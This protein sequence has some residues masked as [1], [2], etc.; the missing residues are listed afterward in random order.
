[1]LI[2]ENL[3]NLFFRFRKVLD[4]K[5][6]QLECFCKYGVQIEGWLKGELLCFLDKEKIIGTLVDFDREVLMGIG[7]KKVDFKVKISTSSGEIETWIELKH[8]LIGY[9]KGTKYN[10]Q[11]YFGDSCEIRFKSGSPAI[12]VN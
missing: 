11:F 10:A 1:V 5:Q 6:K 8:W 12:Y 9:Q 4:S 2:E 7:K 3:K